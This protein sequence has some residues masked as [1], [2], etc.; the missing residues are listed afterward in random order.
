MDSEASRFNFMDIAGAGFN[1]EMIR[2]MMKDKDFDPVK[3]AKLMINM[4]KDDPSLISEFLQNI[5]LKN[6][7]GEL[8]FCAI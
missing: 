2:N 6:N 8:L 7:G 3:F 4:G 5:D 1:Q